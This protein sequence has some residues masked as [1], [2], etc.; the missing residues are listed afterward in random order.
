MNPA[1]QSKQEDLDIDRLE[2]GLEE[3]IQLCERLHTENN[4]LRGHQKPLLT[5][6]TRLIETNSMVRNKMESVIKR[7]KM[8]ETEL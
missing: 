5:E 1:P 7:L 6:R 3:L 4:L 8:M 2:S